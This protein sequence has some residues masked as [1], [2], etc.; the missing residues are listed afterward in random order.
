[1]DKRNDLCYP[2]ASIKQSRDSP[3]LANYLANYV[4]FGTKGA[5]L[6]GRMV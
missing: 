4:G 5:L 1:M 3:G 6:W 2:V